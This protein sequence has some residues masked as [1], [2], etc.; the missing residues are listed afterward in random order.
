MARLIDWAQTLK[1]GELDGRPLSPAER[2]LFRLLCRQSTVET[3]DVLSE[4][5]RHGHKR[6]ARAVR[7]M[8]D[9][10]IERGY[11]SSLPSSGRQ[12]LVTLAHEM[13]EATARG[14][15]PSLAKLERQI[16]ALAALAVNLTERLAST[17][18]GDPQARAALLRL[19]NDLPGYQAY[20][21]AGVLH[22]RPRS[23][24]SK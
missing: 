23:T 22:F 13:P 1:Q 9:R 10:W 21:S 17:L 6:T 24:T 20:E 4:L 5:R 7:L 3:A 14:P 16:L 12:R 15:L 19:L 18:P 11:L 2:D 8:L